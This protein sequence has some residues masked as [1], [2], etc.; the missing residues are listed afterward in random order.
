[1]RWGWGVGNT[2]V[3]V[4][5]ADEQ[6]IRIRGKKVPWSDVSAA[7]FAKWTVMYSKEA[8]LSARTTADL[9][10]ALA[11][12]YAEHGAEANA[13]KAR[14]LALAALDSLREEADRLLPQD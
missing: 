12:F 11:V 1:M 10:L 9:L 4:L 5:G 7:Q 6:G 13:A 14:E 2:A 8:R 3:D